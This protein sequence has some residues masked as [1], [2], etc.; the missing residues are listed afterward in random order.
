MPTTVLSAWQGQHQRSEAHSLGPP[1][2]HGES[3]NREETQVNVTAWVNPPSVTTNI[4][5][6]REGGGTLPSGGHGA[7]DPAEE[8]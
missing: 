4:C 7:R 8:A 3:Q 5:A 1:G 6:C 2:T